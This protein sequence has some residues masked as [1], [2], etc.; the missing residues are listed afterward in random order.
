VFSSFRIS[1]YIILDPL[2]KT[3]DIKILKPVR[4][5]LH[6]VDSPA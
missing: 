2:E 4:L 1:V 3:R 6:R 5:A